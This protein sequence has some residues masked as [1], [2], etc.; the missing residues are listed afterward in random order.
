MCFD[1]NGNLA[2]GQ[3]AWFGEQCPT[4]NIVGIEALLMLMQSLVKYGVPRQADTVLVI[5]DS[6]LIIDF[7]NHIARPLKAKLFLGVQ[8]LRELGKHLGARIVYQQVLCE[9]NKI[10]VWLCSVA[11]QLQRGVDLAALAP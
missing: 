10:V 3:G 11:R 8:K 6:Q 2:F 9:E 1:K 5:G 7:A 4:N